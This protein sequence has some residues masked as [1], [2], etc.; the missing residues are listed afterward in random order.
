MVHMLFLSPRYRGLTW[1]LVT[2]L[3]T[4]LTGCN[5]GGGRDPG[6]LVYQTDWSNR[7][8]NITGL[9]QRVIVLNENQVVV[10]AVTV[11]QDADSVQQVE[12]R[13]VGNGRRH[14]HIDLYSGRD[15]GGV[16]TGELDAWIDISGQTIFLTGVGDSPS[17][18]KV[19]PAAATFSVNQSR[20]FYATLYSLPGRATFNAPGAFTW[21]TLGGVAS[22]NQTG[23][24]QGVSEGSGSVRATLT[25]T[26]LT[27]AASITVTPFQT[28]TS[29]WTVM[30]YMN[31][32]NDLSVFTKLNFNQMEKVAG[33]PQNVRFVVQWKQSTSLPYTAYFNGTRRYLVKYDTTDSFDNSELVQDMGTDVDMGDWHTLNQFITWS[34]TYYPAQRY[35]L[36]IWNHGNGWLNRS[37]DAGP[38]RGVSYDDVTN[39]FIRTEQLSQAIGNTA[40][41][42]VAWDAS[43]MQMMEVAYEIKDQAHYVVGSEES[44]PGEGYPYDLIFDDFRDRPDD[45]TASLTDAFVQ[46][47]LSVPGYQT[48]K[49]TQSSIETTKL[50][51]LATA[52]DNLAQ[53][54][55]AN[56]DAIA[57]DVQF[58][59]QTSVTQSY[60]ESA[61]M[62]RHFRDIYHLCQNLE[63]RLSGTFPTIVT[64][65]QQ[66]RSA[67]TQAVVHEGH[68]SQSPNSHGLSIDF[69]SG[70]QFN[71]GSN[72]ADYA[73]LR[74]A[75]DTHWD[76]WLN[77]AP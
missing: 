54:L 7:G 49:I 61:G 11:N 53:L 74:F 64:A 14:L 72:S 62:N 31:G 40:L 42:I 76:E 73:N 70:A 18:V 9:S 65:C 41:D 17:S 67:L 50:P 15:L 46:G 27:G 28:T 56:K 77:V 6:L 37:V 32:A 45:S 33:A 59:R 8:N 48:R 55:I 21:D 66:V 44:P 51:A 39:N 71:S 47:M 68:N 12:I 52:L 75:L 58:V 69:S 4:I 34:K 10:K 22:V 19:S 20:Q 24:V 35:V 16:K 30:V 29:K 57:A 5:S 23:L 1:L 60:S 26:G 36:V 3:A 43:L 13:D 38:T 2:A 25:G 63:A